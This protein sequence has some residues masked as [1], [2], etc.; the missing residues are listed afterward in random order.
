[1]LQRL[2]IE[3]VALI[4]KL[5]LEFSSGFH[6]LSGETGAGKSIIIDAVNFVLG[7]RASRELIKFG[8]ARAKVEAVFNLNGCGKARQL[9]DEMELLPEDNELILSREL[10]QAGKNICRINGSLAPVSALK[11]ITDVLVDIHGQHEHQSLLNPEK[12]MGFLDAFYFEKI[13]L[14]AEKLQATVAAYSLLR[15]ERLSGFASEGER[16]REIDVLRYQIGEIDGAKIEAGEENGLTEERTLL[17]NSEKIH[18]T[19]ESA[20][21]LISGQDGETDGGALSALDDARRRMRE[22]AHFSEEYENVSA[23]LEEAFYSIEDI[24]FT[25]RDQREAAEF[26]PERLDRI[27]ARLEQLSGLKRKYGKTLEEV[28]SFRER[29]DQRLNALVGAEARIAQLDGELARLKKEYDALAAQ[30]TGLRR[31]AAGELR[32]AV[33]A[34]LKDLG[35]EKADFSVSLQDIPGGEPHD[36]G[37]E[38]AESLLSANPGE[39]LKPPEKVASGGER[40]RI[41]LCFKAI[42]AQSDSIPTLIFDEIDTG[43]SGKAASVVGEKM[44][45]IARAHQVICVTH[46]AQIAALADAHY[47]VE[48]HTDGERTYVNVHLLDEEGKNKRIAQ[49]MDG[50]SD[51][52]FALEHAKVLLARAESLKKGK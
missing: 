23:N 13:G 30:L 9:L 19:L 1:M 50:D 27:E 18:S 41:M 10:T 38:T 34:Q 11:S 14:V 26:D 29:A 43:I 32:M 17:L 42:F 3:N 25:L 8:A 12:H 33:L 40:S 44:L 36:G 47:A 7:E 48:K 24:G 45:S 52:V 31:Q 28:L 5:E 15:K 6:V 16:E 49:M 22:I 2:Y 39:P 46:L 35:L 20:W 21:R 51:S 4:E 37:R